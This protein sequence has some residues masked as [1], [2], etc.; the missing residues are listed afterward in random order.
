MLLFACP[1]CGADHCGHNVK[2]GERAIAAV[3]AHPEMSDRGIGEAIN[4]SDKTVAAARRKLDAE[5]S[6]ALEGMPEF[7][8]SPQT[9]K[10]RKENSKHAL[11]AIADEVA[12]AK[13][14]AEACHNMID[15]DITPLPKS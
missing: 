3:R 13:G 2:P 14:N 4:V 6:A 8:A 5:N 1:T 7:S 9:P 11:L 10:Q 12:A 15:H